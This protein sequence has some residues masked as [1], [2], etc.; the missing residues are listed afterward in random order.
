MVEG[1]PKPDHPHSR[2]A[3]PFQLGSPDPELEGPHG[4]YLYAN[5][6]TSPPMPPVMPPTSW[7][8]PAVAN[9]EPLSRKSPALA[10]P[11]AKLDEPQR[12]PPKLPAG[13]GQGPLSIEPARQPPPFPPLMRREAP[14]PVGRSSPPLGA[15]PAGR[16]S[17]R[18]P[19]WTRMPPHPR[20]IAAVSDRPRGYCNQQR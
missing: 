18:R 5:N 6:E 11:R 10:S 2:D 17:D 9:R 1:A 13:V 3:T 8:P 4:R 15:I 16:A 19:S 20:T 12:P 14:S 7:R